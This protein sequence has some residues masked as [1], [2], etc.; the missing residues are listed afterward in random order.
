MEVYFE[1]MEEYGKD[2]MVA[3]ECR[4][5]V[6][7]V[8]FRL[9]VRYKGLGY[10]QRAAN[11]F[12]LAMSMFWDASKAPN[13][14]A[15]LEY[16]LWGVRWHQDFMPTYL[17]HAKQLRRN[18][19]AALPHPK[20]WSVPEDYRDPTLRIAVFSLCDYKPDHKMHWLLDRSRSNRETYT[21]RHGYASEWTDRMRAMGDRHPVWG[22]LAG[23]LQLLEDSSKAYD[24]VLSMDCDS[25]FV[26]MKATLDSLLY[27]FAARD[28]PWGVLQ[29]DPDVHFLISED[30]RGMAGGN[31]MVRNSDQGRELLRSVYGSD[32]A[33]RNPYLKHDLRDQ[34]S[35]LWHLVRP[36]VSL[37]VPEE[38]ATAVGA[39]PAPRR[40]LDIGYRPGVRLVPQEWLLG[41]Y[42][43]VSCSQPGDSGH[44]CFVEETAATGAGDFIVSVPLLGALPQ[45]MAQAMLDSFLLAAVGSLGRPEYE[46]ELRRICPQV[47]ISRCLVQDGGA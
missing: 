31:W 46:E 28:T 6:A 13:G 47:D 3:L 34:F 9:G 24:W 41:S 20:T 25:L 15:C 43:F 37:P 30:G 7:S 29:L 2:A 11:L 4:M 19:F 40:W 33:E 18:D 35:L 38:E 26:N 5:G 17:D 16:E 23:P 27:R 44:R 22:Q 12:Q 42:P 8:F 14:M 32:D 39:P 21:R 1:L 10:A 45:S 36:G